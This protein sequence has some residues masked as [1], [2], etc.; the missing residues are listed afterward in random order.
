[1]ATLLLFCCI[2]CV[3]AHCA[4]EL[5]GALGD[6]SAMPAAELLAPSILLGNID[7]GVAVMASD[8]SW[9]GC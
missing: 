4:A 5:D 2:I 8:I 1:L 6:I 3:D 9:I 7:P